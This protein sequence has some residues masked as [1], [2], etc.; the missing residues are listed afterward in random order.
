MFSNAWRWSLIAA[1]IIALP[2]CLATAQETVAESKSVAVTETGDGCPVTLDVTYSLYSDY[3]FRGINFSEY[4]GEGREKFN[5]QV[6]T[7][8]GHRQSVIWSARS[9]EPAAFSPLPPSSSGSPSRIA[10]IPSRAARTC[11]RWTTP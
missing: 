1:I 7:A 6:T 9:P 5:H 10:S 3:I 8:F 11:R 4:A 2:A